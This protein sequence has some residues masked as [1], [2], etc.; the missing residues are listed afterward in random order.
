MSYCLFNLCGEEGAAWAQAILSGAAI[1]ASGLIA[2]AV[3]W[4]QRK[5]E[6][7]RAR[8]VARE[9]AFEAVKWLV[10]FKVGSE[11]PGFLAR[12][13]EQGWPSVQLSLAEDVISGVPTLQLANARASGQ[14]LAI[15]NQVRMVRYAFDPPGVIDPRRVVALREATD[16]AWIAFTEFEKAVGNPVP[17]REAF[18]AVVRAQR[19]A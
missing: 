11:Q 14:L 6:E 1:L 8:L 3:P 2:M 13:G 12:V 4:Y 19:D 10:A 7:R 16:A 5:G 15:R 18:E 9:A 17:N